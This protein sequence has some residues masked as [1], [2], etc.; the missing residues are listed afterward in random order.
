VATQSYLF[1]RF[2][3][4]AIT[5]TGQI[6]T[7]NWRLA[8]ILVHNTTAKTVR[9]YVYQAGQQIFIA[10]APGNQDTSWNTTGVQLGWDDVD[11]GLIL[12]DYSF[13]LTYPV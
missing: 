6:N 3:D 4:G 1:F 10:D 2:L 8:S 7:A 9:G 5:V 12:G 13:R 11:G